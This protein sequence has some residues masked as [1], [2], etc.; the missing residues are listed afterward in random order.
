MCSESAEDWDWGLL[1]STV[2]A[3]G[4]RETGE[5]EMKVST[6]PLQ[7]EFELVSACRWAVL[8]A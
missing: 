6:I 3:L 5:S 2:L 8:L 4:A 7:G 1:M